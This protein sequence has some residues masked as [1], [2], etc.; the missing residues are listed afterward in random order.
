MAQ[1]KEGAKKA[2]FSIKQRYG[3]DFYKTIGS[4][5]G[6]KSKTGGFASNKVGADGLTGKERASRVGKIGGTI[7]RRN[8]KY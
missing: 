6:K 3:D 5:G 7:S 2:I 4:K 8:K 1:T